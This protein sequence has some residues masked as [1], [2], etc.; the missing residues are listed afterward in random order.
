M[1]PDPVNSDDVIQENGFSDWKRV[2]VAGASISRSAT[3][4]QACVRSVAHLG[5]EKI[6]PL[7]A[8]K[9]RKRKLSEYPA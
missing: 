6:R 1:R 7:W 4:R 2:I 8:R 9:L 3:L 5:I